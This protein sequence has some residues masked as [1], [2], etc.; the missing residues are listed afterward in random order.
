MHTLTHAY[1]YLKNISVL[2]LLTIAF[3]CDANMIVCISLF[4]SIY[5]YLYLYFDVS[6]NNDN[7]E[8]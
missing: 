6:E 7:F 2:Y 8:L 4:V 3:D 1:T 5:R